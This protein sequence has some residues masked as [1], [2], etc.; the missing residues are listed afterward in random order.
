[1]TKQLEHFFNLDNSGEQESAEEATTPALTLPEKQK[2]AEVTGIVIKEQI[3]IAE[4]ING[5]L[6]QVRGL[7]TED[8]E[9]DEYADKAM[10]SYTRLMDLGFNVDDRNAGTIFDVACKMMGA[11]ITAKT[12][13]LDKKLK[14]VQLQLQAA[15]LANTMAKEEDKEQSEDGSLTTDRNA[16]LN[17]ISQ[18]L[19]KDK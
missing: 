4:R 8:R 18:N 2:D 1:M 11:A 13:K 7:E 12:A 10:E 19:K 6:P 15:K 3:S 9:L 16:I 5:A 14:M 17:L